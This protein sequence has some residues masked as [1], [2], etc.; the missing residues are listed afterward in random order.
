LVSDQIKDLILEY[1]EENKN[2]TKNDVVRYMQNHHDPLCRLTRVPT[3]AEINKFE[4][5]GIINVSKRDRRGQAQRLSI[6][7]KI[8]F[9]QIK[10]VL[11]EIEPFINKTNQY[12]AIRKA[13]DLEE[14]DELS[15][16]EDEQDKLAKRIT[17]LIHLDD[18]YRLTMNRI[19]DDLY[20]LTVSTNL[21]K[22][23]SERFVKKI[24]E[25]KSKLQYHD[26][27]VK[28]ENT[29]FNLQLANM[30]QIQRLIKESGLEDYF[31]EKNLKGKFIDP[32]K[33]RIENFKQV[34]SN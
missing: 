1:I 6:N 25:L 15:K 11:E 31:E 14:N 24:I 3:L 23:D 29:F 12:F 33:G 20:H 16:S 7:D 8:K 34:L 32:L 21:P 26:W 9:N 30:K 5:F 4:K 22:E 27:T 2:S 17:L 13:H 28:N 18:L 10:I 19:L